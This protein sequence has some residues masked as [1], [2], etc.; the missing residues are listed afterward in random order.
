MIKTGE[1][2][3]ATNVLVADGHALARLGLLTLLSSAP[4][5]RAVG[6]AADSDGAHALA[7]LHSPDVILMDIA[8]PHLG[9]IAT[10]QRILEAAPARPPRV[11]ITASEVNDEEIQSA[12]RV[13]AAG[14]LL[15]DTSPQKMTASISAVATG[16]MAFS[17]S[18]MERLID[19]YTYR[20]TATDTAG[21][22][23]AMLTSRETEVLRHVAKGRSN[24]AIA[25]ELKISEA[26]VKTHLNR[27]MT[28]LG[29]TSRAEAVALG[30]ECGLVVP[31]QPQRVA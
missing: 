4:G 10:T 8:L 13:G 2:A 24:S 5:L 19:A 15:K 17:P 22:S 29:I 21:S 11:I 18:V 16:D 6:E 27:A 26:T 1:A 28:K 20:A 25:R 30:Y 9:G 31:S 14:I 7:A 23:L 3:A 12:L